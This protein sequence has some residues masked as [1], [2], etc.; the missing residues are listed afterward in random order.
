MGR[1]RSTQKRNKNQKV[2]GR[3]TFLINNK[4]AFL[5]QKTIKIVHFYRHISIFVRLSFKI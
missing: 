3:Y 2:F 4:N 1:G 5:A